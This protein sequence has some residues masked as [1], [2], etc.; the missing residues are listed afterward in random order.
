MKIS[1]KYHHSSK[2]VIDNAQPSC[3]SAQPSSAF[4]HATLDEDQML[5]LFL[6]AKDL[7]VER[8]QRSTHSK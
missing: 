6:D 2:L 3:L 8:R 1:T 5:Y 4:L 7:T